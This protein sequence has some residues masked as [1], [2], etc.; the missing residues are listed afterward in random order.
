MRLKRWKCRRRNETRS[1][2]LGARIVIEHLCEQDVWTPIR[3]FWADSRRM[4]SQSGRV[5]A[6]RGSRSL[7]DA[8]LMLSQSFALLS[9]QRTPAAKTTE[10]QPP[11]ATRGARTPGVSRASSQLRRKS[12]T[13]CLQNS[14]SLTSSWL[15]TLPQLRTATR[16]R[17][18]ERTAKS[19]TTWESGCDEGL[20]AE[21]K[22]RRERERGG[23]FQ[24]SRS[25]LHSAQTVTGLR[26]NKYELQ[27]LL[28]LEVCPRSSNHSELAATEWIAERKSDV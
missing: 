10:R 17:E 5:A 22:R 25:R 6:S 9:S 7:E 19:F 4:V 1:L 2:A 3:D 16:Q 27:E 28:L 26:T 8:T 13:Q 15:H 14:C 20:G 11:L 18:S 12:K 21:E 24:F 23:A